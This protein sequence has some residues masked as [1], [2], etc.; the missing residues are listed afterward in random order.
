METTRAVV[1]FQWRVA[2]VGP[3][4][5]TAIDDPDDV[6][7]GLAAGRHDVMEIVASFLSL[8]VGHDWREDVRG[9]LLDGADDAA[10][11]T[12]GDA[13]P[14]AGLPPRLPFATL[15]LCDL[16]LAQRACGQ[17]L[18]LGAAPPAQPGPGQAPHDRCLCIA[19]DALPATCA[20][21]QGG[22]CKRARGESRRGRLEP[23]RRTAGA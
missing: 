10:P 6:C 7:A 16:A 19:H 14:R 8:K 17:T 2:L 20:G 9:A 3:L 22:A 23:S 11:H 21:L 12:A 13:T 1:V 5:P 15:W 18:P 4:E